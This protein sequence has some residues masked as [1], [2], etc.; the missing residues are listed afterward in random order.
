MDLTCPRC[1]ATNRPVAR[2]CAHCG[3]MLE[4]ADG[5]PLVPGRIRHPDPLPVP[6]GFA[7]CADAV[8]LYFRCESAWGG[9]RLLGTEGVSVILFNGGYPLSDVV[10]NVRGEDQNGRELFA[11]E[12]PTGELPRGKDMMLEIPSYE[13]PDPVHAVRLALVSAEFAP[14][15]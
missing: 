14:D 9:A 1:L 7:P 11:T 8:D 2:F 6:E 5:G 15:T 3:L 4:S 12:H 10:L 13:L